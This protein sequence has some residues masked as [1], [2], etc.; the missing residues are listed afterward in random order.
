MLASVAL[1]CGV[2]SKLAVKELVSL[3]PNEY[4]A[5]VVVPVVHVV[6]AVAMESNVVRTNSNKNGGSKNLACNCTF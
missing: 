2:T 3:F 4:P 6:C 5:H 1:A